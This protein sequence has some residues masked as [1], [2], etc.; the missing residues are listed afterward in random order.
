MP[1]KT[2]LKKE[3]VCFSSQFKCITVGIIWLRKCEAPDPMA[4]AA[5]KQ[6]E[7]NAGVQ[8]I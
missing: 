8:R 6:R 2:Q 5:T 7:M 3:K 4:S 1:D